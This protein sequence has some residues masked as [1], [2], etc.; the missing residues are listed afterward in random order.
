MLMNELE[1]INDVVS[2]YISD[3]NI[4]DMND[5]RFLT[6]L[7]DIFDS[8][9]KEN[10]VRDFKKR[11]SLKLVKKSMTIIYLFLVLLMV[12]QR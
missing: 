2:R 12:K 8:N 7:I 6:S 4:E 11:V 1:L 10:K 9:Y 3:C 5:F